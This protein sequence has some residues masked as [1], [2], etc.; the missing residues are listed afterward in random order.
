MQE[1]DENMIPPL[2]SVF[3]GAIG[4]ALSGQT[5]RQPMIKRVG[6]LLPG[7]QGLFKPIDRDSYAKVIKQPLVFA[8]LGLQQ[9]VTAS[10]SFFLFLPAV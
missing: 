3:L 10:Q 9:R 1:R 8:I 7:G 6:G 2:P 4:V 5:N